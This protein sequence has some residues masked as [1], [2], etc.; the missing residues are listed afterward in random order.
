MPELSRRRPAGASARRIGVSMVSKVLRDALCD[1]CTLAHFPILPLA[2]SETESDCTYASVEFSSAFRL[3]PSPDQDGQDGHR[4][5][6]GR[7]R[8]PN[9]I[10]VITPSVLLFLHLNLLMG[11]FSIVFAR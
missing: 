5:C 7:V 8:T 3:T 9:L 6:A 4:S 1:V 2:L 11:G 10:Y